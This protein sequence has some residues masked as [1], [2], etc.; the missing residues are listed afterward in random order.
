MLLYKNYLLFKILNCANYHYFARTTIWW[1]DS[2]FFDELKIANK[3]ICKIVHNIFSKKFFR[4]Y[5]CKIL[6]KMLDITYSFLPQLWE[7]LQGG[8]MITAWF[9]N[10][11]DAFMESSSPFV[12]SLMCICKH[13]NYTYNHEQVCLFSKN[14]RH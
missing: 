4:I 11:T 10:D 2:T 6:N 8:G 1:K 13:I 5:F 12:I 7:I 3:Y 9:A 14:R